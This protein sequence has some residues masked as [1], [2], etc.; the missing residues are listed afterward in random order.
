MIVCLIYIYKY[1]VGNRTLRP[2]VVVLVGGLAGGYTA[3]GLRS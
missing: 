1:L 2:R 3:T